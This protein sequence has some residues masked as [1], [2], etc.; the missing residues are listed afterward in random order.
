MKLLRTQ[1][2]IQVTGLSHM[3]IWR[4]ERSGEFPKRRRLG[5]ISVAWIEDD[6][7]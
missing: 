6:I 5:R 2:V 3:T 7:S 1:Q 4:L